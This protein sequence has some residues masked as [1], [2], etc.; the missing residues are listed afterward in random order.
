VAG[1]RES[2]IPRREEGI[3]LEGNKSLSGKESQ[4][5]KKLP[6]GSEDG[7]CRRTRKLAKTRRRKEEPKVKPAQV[8]KDAGD[9]TGR[10]NLL[11]KMQLAER[12][13]AN[14]PAFN[15]KELHKL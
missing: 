9:T 13:E 4:K 11:K 5:K 1:E 10:R 3:R 12:G 7:G 15:H 8:L 14:R 6:I 2:T